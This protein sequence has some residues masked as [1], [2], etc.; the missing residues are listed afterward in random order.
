MRD[1]KKI[2][3]HCTD[4]P[5]DLDIGFKEINQ[6]HKDRGWMSPSGISCGYHYIIRRDGR[7]DFGRPEI[8]MGAHVAGHNRD[9]I[10][11]VWVGRKIIDEEKQYPK[12][13]QIVR[14]VLDHHNLTVDDVYGHSELFKGKTCPNIDM[15][16][17]RADLLFTKREV[18]YD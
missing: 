5:D 1:I 7:I 12:L 4:S 9:S 6:W 3:V 13:L 18:E 8:E 14:D 16:I 2:V 15:N 11:I 10:G 17:V